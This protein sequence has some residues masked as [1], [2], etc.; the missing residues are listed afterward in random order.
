MTPLP[1]PPAHVASVRIVHYPDRV[2]TRAALTPEQLDHLAVTHVVVSKRSAIESV[3][4]A[5]DG[6]APVPE[7][8]TPDSRWGV[9]LLDAHGAT[10]ARVYLDKFGKRALIDGRGARVDGEPVVQLL[11]KLAPPA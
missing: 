1:V 10:I 7:Q 6:M 8:V 9:T 11:A 5:L 2:L 4:R 3:V